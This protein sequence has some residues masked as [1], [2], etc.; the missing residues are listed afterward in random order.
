MQLEKI[1]LRNFKSYSGNYTVGPFDKFT[2]IV[3]PNGSGKSN[4]LDGITFATNVS[5]N[6][7][8]VKRAAELVSNGFTECEVKL[9]ITSSEKHRVFSRSYSCINQTYTY[10]INEKVV[11]SAIYTKELEKINIFAKIRNFIIYQG[12]LLNENVDLF[13]VIE[14]ISNSVMYKDEYEKLKA[15]HLACSKLLQQK[16]EKKKDIM[17]D[18]NEMNE[19][20]DKER[21]F[22][23]NMQEQEELT[24]KCYVLETKI[25]ENELKKLGVEFDDISKRMCSLKEDSEYKRVK[26]DVSDM[27]KQVAKEYKEFYEIDTEIKCIREA[28][29]KE[30]GELEELEKEKTLLQKSIEK[31]RS[32]ID[33][34]EYCCDEEDKRQQFEDDLFVA[35]EEYNKET[36][37]E[38]KE[39]CKL[40]LDNYERISRKEELLNEIKKFNEKKNKMEKENKSVEQNNKLKKEAKIKIDKILEELREKA[41]PEALNQLQKLEEDMK[42]RES[43]LNQFTKEILIH[44]AKFNIS[45]NEIFVSGVIENLKAINGGVYGKI[46]K[47]IQPTQECYEVPVSV[48]IAKY[49]NTVVVEN[50]KTAIE[51]I[52]YLKETK[53][54]KLTFLCLDRFTSTGYRNGAYGEICMDPMDCVAYENRYVGIVEHIFKDK[55][56]ITTENIEE[57]QNNFKAICTTNGSYY[58]RSG[59]ITGGS[60]KI[61]KYEENLVEELSAKRTR[62]L[63]EIKGIKNKKESFTGINIY[64]DKIRELEKKKET[65]TFEKETN[66]EI[67]MEKELERLKVVNEELSNLNVLLQDYEMAKQ[68]IRE[69][70]RVKE[71]KTLAPILNKIGVETYEEYKAKIQDEEKRIDL[72]EN[73]KNIETK[74]ANLTTNDNDND[75][76]ESEDKYVQIF[77]LNKKQVEIQNKLEQSK[78]I[79]RMKNATYTESTRKIDDLNKKMMNNTLTRTKYAEEIKDLIGFCVLETN[80]QNEDEITNEYNKI[81]ITG[82][83]IINLLNDLKSSKYKVQQELQANVPLGLMQNDTLQSKYLKFNREYEFAKNAAQQAKAHFNEIA[84]HRKRLFDQYF[85]TLQRQINSV[86]KKLAYSLEFDTEIHEVGKVVLEGDP[87]A[88]KNAIKFYVMPPNKGYTEFR[89]LSGG[90]KSLAILSFIFA[91]QKVPPFYVLDEVDTALDRDNVQRLANFITNET[92]G[93]EDEKQFLVIS[94]KDYFFKNAESLVGVYKDQTEN[95]SKILTY[96]FV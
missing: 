74:I 47:L 86:Y 78:Q 67:A 94:L 12:V 10:K 24:K 55:A 72:T 80:L 83:N 22:L 88:A 76:T 70:F 90:E 26:E 57:F 34:E 20:K 3:G 17:N 50:E 91:I 16:H 18:M 85:E 52:N 51:C 65:Y 77:N 25:K 63:N 56:I 33:Y 82:V 9:H 54:C 5:I 62:V 71:K 2:C 95:R 43:E 41:T 21:R 93:V 69:T 68:F 23:K 28:G 19:A 40:T 79:L 27:K 32:P 37:E 30:T 1:E 96:K 36:A 14:K 66:I 11:Q 49:D 42:K 44:K 84:V 31:L 61:N 45:K 64:M 39:E 8:R 13:N 15:N 35:M 38:Q 4:I 60:N 73:L 92:N 59:L 89:D 29:N 7:L 87:F 81:A 53:S 6:F 48:L 58:Q 75:K 46:S